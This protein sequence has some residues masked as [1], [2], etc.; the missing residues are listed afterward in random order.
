MDAFFVRPYA[1]KVNMQSADHPEVT[2]FNPGSVGIPKGRH[3]TAAGI[4]EDGEFSTS[5]W[6]SKPV[7]FTR[8]KNGEKINRSSPFVSLSLCQRF[9]AW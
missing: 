6:A 5:S 8:S 7:L 1:Q 2:V 4:Y 3:C 9:S